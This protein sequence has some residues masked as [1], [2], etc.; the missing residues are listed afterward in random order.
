MNTATI[1]TNQL[2]L[3]IEEL[4]LAGYNLGLTQFLMAQQLILTLAKQ[5]ALP[6]QPAALKTLLRPI[7]C[8]SPK[9]QAEFDRRF[10][11]WTHQLA[12]LDRPTRLP[13]Q[14]SFHS[15][16]QGPHQR[17]KWGLVIAILLLISLFLYPFLKATTTLL[18]LLP[19]LLLWLGRRHWAKLY[20]IR[21]FSS[22]QPAI[23]RLLEKDLS[24]SI[25]PP[26]PWWRTAQQLRQPLTLTTDQL[27][28]HTTLDQT[29]QATGW[30]T[31]VLTTT[32][33]FPKYLAIIE[34][35]SCQDHQAELINTLL[36]QLLAAGV[37]INRYYFATDPRHCYPEA[38][39]LSP[40]TLSE[41]AELHPNHHPMIFSD[42]NCLFHTGQLVHWFPPFSPWTKRILFTLVAP[43]QW[44]RRE[45]LLEQANFLVL[46][47]QETGFKYLMTQLN[48]N[49]WQSY[50]TASLPARSWHSHSYPLPRKTANFPRLL[51]ENPRIWL[52]P[53]A[54]TMTD[55]AAMLAQVRHFLGKEGYYWFSACA[56][57]PELHWPL[58]LY[59]GDKLTSAPGQS[60]LTA[61]T[62]TKLVRL[63]WFR[64]G[65]LPLWL[66]QQ[67]VK[68]LLSQRRGK[69]IYAALAA[70][71][72]T[73]TKK[74]SP[75]AEN[76]L[77]ESLFVT[78]M[79]KFRS[80]GGSSL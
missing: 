76:P 80:S 65:H 9:E 10:D 28:L 43:D 18:L 12:N 38:N 20:L 53:R 14:L 7:L 54:P 79:A 40:L 57:Y 72:Q 64:Q 48:A 23:T 33:H 46:P 44:G 21:K 22:Y 19:L 60:L 73:A 30:F 4:R 62:L 55:V 5:G 2:H 77:T 17:W 24:A 36:N 59:L 78:F 1:L 15:L 63:P 16:M 50:Q 42:G 61:E 11:N 13:P 37:S 25:F 49:S 47:T 29:I 58:T 66:R 69:E 41:L 39:D 34:R 51:N 56:V 6:A 45:H 74:P 68:E 26:I 70:I 52:E 35:T 27:D 75:I 71:W 67:L 32:E 8:H 3:F 31:P